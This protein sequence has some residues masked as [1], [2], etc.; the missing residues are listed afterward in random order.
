[1]GAEPGEPVEAG[2]IPPPFPPKGAGDGAED[3]SA[4]G[5]VGSNG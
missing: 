5:D 1:M 2:I 3:A 4:G